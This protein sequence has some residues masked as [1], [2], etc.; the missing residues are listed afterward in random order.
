MFPARL[1]EHSLGIRQCFKCQAWGHTSNACSR[2]ARCGHCAGE[3]S[4]KECDRKG[5]PQCTNCK[6]PH[7]AWN[8]ARCRVF[9]AYLKEVQAKRIETSIRSTKLHEEARRQ[10]AHQAIEREGQAPAQLG[11]KRPRQTGPEYG[12]DRPAP[13]RPRYTT[14]AARSPSQSKLRFIPTIQQ[15]NFQPNKEQAE[16]NDPNWDSDGSRGGEE[17]EVEVE[18]MDYLKFAYS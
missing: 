18:G 10:Q 13:G 16:N 9:T 3:H 7:P 2:T 15:F 4:T 6:G 8:R 14:Q 1:Y 12:P 11:Q 5:S 17:T